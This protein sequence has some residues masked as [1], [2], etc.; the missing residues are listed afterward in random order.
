MPQYEMSGKYRAEFKTLDSFTRGYIEAG[1]WLGDEEQGIPDMD[2]CDL[3]P[4]ALATIIHECRAFQ[5]A[6]AATLALA[7]EVE[8]YDIEQAGIDYWL[9]RNRHGAGYWD[10]GLG[11][12]G[13]DLTDAAHADGE[14]DLYIAGDGKIYY[15]V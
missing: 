12:V 13:K 2:F 8:G 14:R 4:A 6:N 11:Q 9:T 5:E 15:Y 1:Y 7:M 10:R 3:A